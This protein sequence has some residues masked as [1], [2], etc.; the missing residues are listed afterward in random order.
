MNLNSPSHACSDGSYNPGAGSDSCGFSAT[1]NRP[2]SW[3]FKFNDRVCSGGLQ[4]TI[5]GF[6]PFI[7]HTILLI[8]GR[9]TRLGLGLPCHATFIT[10]HTWVRQQSPPPIT[11][12]GLFK[13]N[14]TQTPL[15]SPIHP[16]LTTSSCRPRT[17]T[18]T[19]IL[20]YVHD[21]SALLEEKLV[22]VI[23]TGM[24]VCLIMAH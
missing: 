14:S 21:T 5:L 11:Y 22:S 3:G 9:N 23:S 20:V 7:L 1:G 18:H 24:R 10:A 6:R 16:Q 17:L 12:H 13:L 4:T 19:G 15:I 8:P 2:Q